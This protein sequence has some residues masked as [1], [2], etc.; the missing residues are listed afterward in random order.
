M[1]IPADSRSY[2]LEQP[3]RS[4]VTQIS[5]PLSELHSTNAKHCNLKD[6]RLESLRFSEWHN[7]VR[8]SK[9]QTSASETELG[10]ETYHCALSI[11]DAA[12]M[13]SLLAY[14]THRNRPKLGKLTPKL[15]SRPRLKS[16]GRRQKL[17]KGKYMRERKRKAKVTKKVQRDAKFPSRWL[18][19]TFIRSSGFH[20]SKRLRCCYTGSFSLNMVIQ[21]RH[22]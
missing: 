21:V 6:S 17:C 2:L 7:Y 1:S 10:F 9:V 15:R 12:K 18:V 14:N 22:V 8:V 11:V 20:S 13:I 4:T 19:S 3:L 16:W 5:Q